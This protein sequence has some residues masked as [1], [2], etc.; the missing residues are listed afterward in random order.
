L[1][2]KIEKTLLAIFI[3]WNPR[4]LTTSDA[5]PSQVALALTSPQ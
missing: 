3:S 4:S 5:K 1:A 2:K